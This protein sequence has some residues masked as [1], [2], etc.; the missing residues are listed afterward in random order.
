MHGALSQTGDA[1]FENIGEVVNLVCSVFIL[2]SIDAE[3]VK[4]PPRNTGV[5]LKK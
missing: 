5:I 3:G 2:A 4:N 1:A